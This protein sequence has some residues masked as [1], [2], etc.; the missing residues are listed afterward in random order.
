MKEARCCQTLIAMAARSGFRAMLRSTRRQRWTPSHRKV[1]LTSWRRLDRAEGRLTTKAATTL[2][3]Q[4]HLSI[5]KTSS[6]KS[7]RKPTAMP[8]RPSERA[9]SRPRETGSMKLTPRKLQPKNLWRI[10]SQGRRLVMT[11]RGNRK[12]ITARWAH[13]APEARTTW[14]W[15][16]TQRSAK[17]QRTHSRP[18]SKALSRRSAHLL[19]S[20]GIITTQTNTPRMVSRMWMSSTK[21]RTTSL[22][23]PSNHLTRS[24]LP[25]RREEARCLL[26]LMATPTASW[27]AGSVTS[28]T[29]NTL[30]RMVLLR[31]STT[32]E[33]IK[34]SIKRS[35]ERH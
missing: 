7:R 32:K 5:T 6:K 31:N 16:K 20:R 3:R 26:H 9:E 10:Q 14:G 1:G 24:L 13:Q 28:T 19:R 25:R 18:Q 22:P 23:R 12:Q 11:K 27:R 29:W 30:L 21:R 15:A 4:E 8:Q 2:E 35:T 33:S 34:V 17:R